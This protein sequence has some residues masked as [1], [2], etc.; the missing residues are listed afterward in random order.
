MP[1]RTVVGVGFSHDLKLGGH[2]WTLIGNVYNL[3]NAQYWAGGGWGAG[4]LGEARNV[5]LALRT[6]F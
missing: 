1:D 2:D 6:Q 5:S 3:F 4:N